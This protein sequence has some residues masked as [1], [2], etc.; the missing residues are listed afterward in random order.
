M[1]HQRGLKNKCYCIKKVINEILDTP[2][3]DKSIESRHS[4]SKT[5]PIGLEESTVIFRHFIHWN[6]DTHSLKLRLL[7]V[8]EEEGDEEDAEDFFNTV[9]KANRQ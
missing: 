5:G 4:N 3:K 9:G 1:K 8:N 2:T 7:Y 6:I